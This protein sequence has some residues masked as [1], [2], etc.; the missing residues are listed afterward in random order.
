MNCV[1]AVSDINFGT[2]RKHGGVISTLQKPFLPSDLILISH[3]QSG[4]FCLVLIH[5]V[6]IT[7]LADDYILII[8]LA[9]ACWPLLR[10]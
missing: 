7:M 2:D 4:E 5:L 10:N 8:L 3:P 1:S 9:M 6:I